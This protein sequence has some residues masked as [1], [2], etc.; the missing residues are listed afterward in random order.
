M[1]TDP[2]SP[3]PPNEF[4][5]LI[6][7]HQ[8]WQV[9]EDYGNLLKQRPL[10]RE[11]LKIYF[12]NQ[13]L[14]AW[15]VPP[16][17]LALSVRVSD[18][19]MDRDPFA[20]HAVAAKTLLAGIHEYGLHAPERLGFAKPHFVLLKE[21]HQSWG[22]DAE[23]LHRLR[24]SADILPE[25]HELS[26][27]IH[28]YMRV[29]PVAQGIGAHMAIEVTADREWELNYLAFSHLWQAYGLSGPA[30]PAIGFY[31]IH[32]EQEPLHARLTADLA[33]TYADLGLREDVL[34]GVSS[35]LEVWAR[36]I[37]AIH[38]FVARA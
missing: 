5:L 21:A 35:F 18:D 34:A 16:G 9:M 11:A 27:C 29:R 26:R 2:T 24:D 17:I 22:F 19:W 28:E 30:S 8:G 13:M 4:E 25:A 12:A 6:R 33:Q 32:T 15:E 1:I 20:A 37:H 7:N 3:P 38:S 31:D 10:P 36:W 14:T 23:E